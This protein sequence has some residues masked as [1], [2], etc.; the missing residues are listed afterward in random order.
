MEE[1]EILKGGYKIVEN[2][3]TEEELSY[4][5]YVC[6]TTWKTA[7]ENQDNHSDY[8][9]NSADNLNKVEGA[10]NFEPKFLE[11]LSH[12]TLVKTAKE[13]INTEETIDVYI[14]KFFPMQPKVGESTYLHQD[15]YYFD[16][17]PKRIVSCAVYL[18]DT[19]KENGCLR[20][21]ENSH[22]QGI[23]PHDVESGIGGI[24]YIDENIL[25]DYK[26]LDLVLKSPY[27]VF[28]DIN[29]IHGCYPNKSD[30]TR[31]SLA[32]EYIK[33]SNMNVLMTDEP[34]CDRNTIR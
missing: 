10:C 8:A 12:P 24:R 11:L 32:C 25:S 9:W 30:I 27:A 16:G 17:N 7:L 28:F 4:Y 34:W 20:L 23:F 5:L 1:K 29:M 3:L 19:S 31:F 6:D 22:K 18:Q 33:T 14:S 26:I 21:V 2:F 15:N 13:I